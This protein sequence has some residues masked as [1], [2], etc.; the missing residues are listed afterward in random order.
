MASASGKTSLDLRRMS[1]ESGTCTVRSRVLSSKYFRRLEQNVSPLLVSIH[2]LKSVL[3]PLDHSDRH[4]DPARVEYENLAAFLAQLSTAANVDYDNVGTDFWS[5]LDYSTYSHGPLMRAF[6]KKDGDQET[7]IL[8]VRLACIWLKYAARSVRALT[9][10]KRNL[11]PNELSQKFRQEMWSQI[12]TGLM[13]A[14]EEFAAKQAEI[15]DELAESISNSDEVAGGLADEAIADLFDKQEALG[16]TE[17][18]LRCAK[19]LLE[20]ALQ[21]VNDVETTDSDG[22]GDNEQASGS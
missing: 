7:R 22:Q 12:K 4:D 9:V 21:A 1:L 8:V 20:E 10:H 5:L 3:D 2:L 11:G 6:V 17:K 18:Q 15:A 13:E 19:P 14:I 16:W